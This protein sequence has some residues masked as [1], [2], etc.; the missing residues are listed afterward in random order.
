VLDAA[1][2]TNVFAVLFVLHLA[3]WGVSIRIRRYS[4]DLLRSGSCAP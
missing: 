1:F 4:D 3:Q 2:A